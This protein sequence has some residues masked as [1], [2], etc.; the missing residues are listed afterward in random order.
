M[1]RLWFSTLILFSFFQSSID[2][3]CQMPCGI[4]HDDMVYDQIDQFVE[5]VVKGISVMEDNHFTTIQDRNEFIRWVV[6]KEN[7][8][9]ETAHLI[10]TYFLQQKIKPGEEDTPKRIESAHKLLFLL[11]LIKQGVGLGPVNDF[12]EEWEKF[13]LMFHIEGYECKMEQIKLKKWV[14]KQKQALQET[15]DPSSHEKNDESHPH[16]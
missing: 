1:K 14:E 13:K 12:Y 7:L 15:K 9:N 10:M 16:H 4:Y 5:T 6:Q 2:A 3:H 11:V 8:A